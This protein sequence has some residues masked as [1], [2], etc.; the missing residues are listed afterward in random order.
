VCPAAV[1]YAHVWQE[2]ALLK[3]PHGRLPAA[4]LGLVSRALEKRP[5]AR[6]Q[7]AAE[8]AADI[9]TALEA[10]ERSGWRRL[11]G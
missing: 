9:G 1:L 2:P 10:L 11:L 3:S 5:G 4:V 8:L 7:T 6:H